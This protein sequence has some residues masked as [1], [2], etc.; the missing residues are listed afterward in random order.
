MSPARCPCATPVT[1][2]VAAFYVQLDGLWGFGGR[3]SSLPL[4][5]YG[6]V[7]VWGTLVVPHRFCKAGEV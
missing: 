7:G 6:A 3:S 4:R 5:G 1:M 2:L